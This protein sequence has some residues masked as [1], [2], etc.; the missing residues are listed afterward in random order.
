MLITSALMSRLTSFA[1]TQCPSKQL[2]K[3]GKSDGDKEGGGVGEEC[4][5]YSSHHVTAVAA[6]AA[7]VWQ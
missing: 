6:A 5:N 7:A 4:E 3:L 1:I 2:T